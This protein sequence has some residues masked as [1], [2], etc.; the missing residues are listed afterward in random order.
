MDDIERFLHA[1][2]TTFGDR[3]EKFSETHIVFS[4]GSAS[5]DA[6]EFVFMDPEV[7]SLRVNWT[8][9]GRDLFIDGYLSE[10]DSFF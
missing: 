4:T 6:G 5:L 10:E 1:I 7:S 8:F 2:R 9:Q 3:I